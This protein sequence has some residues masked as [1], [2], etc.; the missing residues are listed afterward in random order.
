MKKSVTVI[1]ILALIF[2]LSFCLSAFAAADSV[3][4][5]EASTMRLA[6][7]EGSVSV[8]DEAGEEISFREDMRLYSGNSVATEADS[9]AGIS[10]D[11][12]KTVTL[13]E[14]SSAALQQ[15]G[16]KLR[17]SLQTGAMYFSVYQPLAFDEQFEIETSTMV[18]GIRGTAGYVENISATESMVILTSGKVLL[19]ASSGEEYWVYPGQRVVIRIDPEGAVF[20]ATPIYPS[21]YPDFLREELAADP[22]QFDS[23]NYAPAE[24]R[25]SSVPSAPSDPSGPSRPSTD[26]GSTDTSSTD[27]S[28]TDTGSTD[29][30]STDTG[31]S[32]TGGSSPFVTP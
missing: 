14:S 11:E 26:T 19:T 29:T 24:P 21:G 2:T 15:E 18:L 17:V 13:D 1:L 7:A 3:E 5:A 27:T 25:G 32:G 30:G 6:R 8:K 12:V 20:D 23:Y 9:R 10:L 22:F 4:S 16:K 31:S 28:S